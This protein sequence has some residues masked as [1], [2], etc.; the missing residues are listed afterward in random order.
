MQKPEDEKNLC[1]KIFILLSKRFGLDE[2][3]NVASLQFDN[4]EQEVNE[5]LDKFLD[6]PE[7]L[8]IHQI[9]PRPRLG[10][11]KA[12]CASLVIHRH[13]DFRFSA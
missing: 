1:D 12:D 6:H 9:A 3:P 4:Q 11:K 13:V 7:A 8:R 2:S 5:K 10:S